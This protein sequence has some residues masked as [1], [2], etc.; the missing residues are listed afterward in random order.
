MLQ[1]FLQWKKLNDFQK[2]F[3]LINKKSLKYISLQMLLLTQKKLYFTFEIAKFAT[4]W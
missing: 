3:T 2:L 4:S 1:V